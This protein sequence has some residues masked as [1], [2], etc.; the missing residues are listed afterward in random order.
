MSNKTKESNKTKQRI[1][2]VEISSG[3]LKIV[4]IH[5]EFL[6]RERRWKMNNTRKERGRWM[7]QSPEKRRGGA[8]GCLGDWENG[9]RCPQLLLLEN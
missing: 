4:K 8:A 7:P 9:R 2:Q 3:S 5:P 6:R 1:G